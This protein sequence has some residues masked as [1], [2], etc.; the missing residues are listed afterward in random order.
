MEKILLALG[1]QK[2]EKALISA[3]ENEYEFVGAVVYREA[4]V[5]AIEQKSPN[6]VVIREGLNGKENIMQMLYSIR[7]RFPNIRIVFLA[8]TRS[9]GDEFL[10]TLVNYSI[11]DIS[12]EGTITLKDILSLIRH[13]KT[14]DNVKH[15]QP[16]PKID[17]RTNKVV[18]EAP[19]A[20]VQKET[21][22]REVYVD[23]TNIQRGDEP[24]RVEKVVI[25]EAARQYTNTQD[26]DEKD[27]KKSFLGRF[28]GDK[29]QRK[30]NDVENEK[31]QYREPPIYEEPQNN[32]RPQY[33]PISHSQQVQYPRVNYDR[34]VDTYT[35]GFES[36]K[37]NSG[38]RQKIITF[39]GS[40]NGVGNT[41]IAINVAMSLAQKKS[42][43]LFMELNDKFP[44]VSYWYELNNTKDGI[45][46][47]LKGIQTQRYDLIDKSI[48]R[49]K[50]LKLENNKNEQESQMKRNYKKF[51]DDL[52]FMFY[53]DKYLLENKS[54]GYSVHEQEELLRMSKDLYFYLMVQCN[55]DYVILDVQP[56]INRSEVLNALIYSNKVF[57]T[58]TQDVSSI[59]TNLFNINELN[60]RGIKLAP[61]LTYIINKYEKTDLPIQDIKGWVQ[62]D[63]I[64]SIPYLNK[65]F[66]NANFLGLPLILNKKNSL[67][68]SSFQEIEKML[69]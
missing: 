49:T 12:Y 36:F 32:P 8:T 43:V 34:N 64:V 51:P 47:A 42:K 69:L 17:E 50:D 30:D 44:A 58:M 66:V 16:V 39:M 38:A 2:V 14:Y 27:T 19:E 55:Y 37:Q 68:R 60:Q 33:E 53:S 45:D 4:L 31:V 48:I 52:D 62:H 26:D 20:V 6:I 54:N 35:K 40:K 28:L 24:Q 25:D 10:A 22:I 15:L 46:E 7:N 56:D 1:N 65:E 57:V 23:D 18:F 29:E 59:G 63:T 61:K 5:R 67:E 41:S 13:K 21:I 3:L 11:Y 9:P